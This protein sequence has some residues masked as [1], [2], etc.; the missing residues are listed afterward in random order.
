[1]ATPSA[2]PIGRPA[3][4]RRL[5]WSA[6]QAQVSA[7]CTTANGRGAIRPDAEKSEA[8]D[9]IPQHRGMAR[10]Q[11]HLR[12]GSSVLPSGALALDFL[13]IGR[14]RVRRLPARTFDPPH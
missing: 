11:I 8:S 3:A 14:K 4:R 1:M 6:N 12:Y 2:A 13:I 7:A 5:A 9:S 10:R